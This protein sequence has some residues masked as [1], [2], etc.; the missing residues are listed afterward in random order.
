MERV[1]EQVRE[2]PGVVEAT[3]SWSGSLT[4][5]GSTAVTATVADGTPEAEQQQ[6][7]DRAAELVWR[8]QVDPVASL[9]ILVLTPSTPPD[10]PGLQ[11]R[12]DRAE[13]FAELEQAYGPRP[14][15]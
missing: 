11:L 3:G 15:G 8:S 4:T 10:A 5:T 14:V 2:V 7:A 9:S 1:V 12:F 6:V 13:R